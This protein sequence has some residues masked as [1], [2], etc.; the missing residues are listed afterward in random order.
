MIL[1]TTRAV[2]FLSFFICGYFIRL[3]K[4]FIKSFIVI[5]LTELFI[6]FVV[7]TIT[8]LFKK[9]EFMKRRVLAIMFLFVYGI[10][11]FPMQIFVRTLTGKNI[12]LDVEASDSIENVKAKIQDKEGIIP[13][14]QRLIFAGKQ[15]VDGRTLSDYN[16]Q[17]E[18]T[19]HLVI[20][21]TFEL[22]SS[23][24]DTVRAI[25]GQE[26][27]IRLPDSLFNVLPDSFYL[28]Q[29]NGS[30]LPSWI[31]H[32]DSIQ[33][34]KGIPDSADTLSLVVKATLYGTVFSVD[35]INLI[36]Q[37]PVLNR[38]K[39]S[40]QNPAEVKCVGDRLELSTFNLAYT[41]YTASGMLV[42]RGFATAPV[43]DITELERG[44]YIVKID[45]KSY[46]FLKQ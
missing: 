31:S 39:Q 12:T 37:N 34:Y 13:E 2:L 14:F 45:Q 10:S 30:A 25:V 38:L 40:Q 35:T 44:L 9:G 19:L 7:F 4:I 42:Q 41:I 11:L 28:Q 32:V 15:L 3:I 1:K 26:M 17:K 16:I 43:I 20:K 18:S 29:A 46:R 33:V 5:I 36:I 6:M 23:F 22:D 24:Q 21:D 27:Q 8:C